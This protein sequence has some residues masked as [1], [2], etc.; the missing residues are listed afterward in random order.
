MGFLCCGGRRRGHTSRS[1]SG[2]ERTAA[3]QPEPS[4]ATESG[5]WH[6]A[7]EDFSI[8]EGHSPVNSL[9]NSPRGSLVLER[10]SKEHIVKQLENTGSMEPNGVSHDEPLATAGIKS[11]Q[12]SNTA[13]HTNNEEFHDT[14]GSHHAEESESSTEENAEHD[15]KKLTVGCF[16][17]LENIRLHTTLSSGR[18][19]GHRVRR[20]SHR[21]PGKPLAGA[22]LQKRDEQVTI[23]DAR[24]CWD[25]VN[26]S[27]F[28]I[29][30]ADYVRSRRK[31]K[32]EK[33]IYQLLAVDYFN[34]PEKTY[35]IAKQVQLPP[36]NPPAALVGQNAAELA[37]YPLFLIFNIQCPLYPPSIFGGRTDGVGMSMVLYYK[38][39]DDF[40]PQ[41][42]ENR[43]A[44]GLLKRFL[45]NG[46][47]ADQTMTRDRLKLIPRV[48]NVDELNS[49]AL[50]S[51]G[52]FKLLQNYNE[53]PILTR[54]QQEFFHGRNY[55]EVD[56][57]IHQYTYLARKA[58]T[59]FLT[60]MKE[61]V[62]E[63]GLVLQGNGPD[64]L[65]EQIL[66]GAKF[67]RVDFTIQ[68]HLEQYV[69]KLE[70]GQHDGDTAEELHSH[71]GQSKVV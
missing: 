56:L 10:N 8:T 28:K 13:L 46:R 16:S 63:V 1:Q 59:G 6:D 3:H 69:P 44:L 30:G 15:S 22:S 50:L 52:E 49:K 7:R 12:N 37:H 23:D 65:P 42:F 70:G 43:A 51:I 11:G 31:Q 68:R 38:L 39:R 40:D 25:E 60:R 20:S 61:V 67:C 21:K 26:G 64:E 9:H 24:E 5:C 62:F 14:L 71:H 32:S 55:L 35:H 58:F 54:P 33:A 41:T 66:A 48:V 17:I 34:F 19:D 47:E 29:R 57:D 4:I 2:A 36:A 45:Q 27:E 53:K 18:E